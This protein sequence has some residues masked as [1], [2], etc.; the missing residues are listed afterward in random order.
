MFRSNLAFGFLFFQAIDGRLEPPPQC[1]FQLFLRARP[2]EGIDRLSLVVEGN[3]AA[4]NFLPLRILRYELRED[5]LAAWP[6]LLGRI[7]VQTRRR[8]LKHI[9]RSP[10]SSPRVAVPALLQELQLF[11]E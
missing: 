10:R 2:V 11:L 4:G 3:V 5:A 1:R 8:I 6:W 7:E 9:L